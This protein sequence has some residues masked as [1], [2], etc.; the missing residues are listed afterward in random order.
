MNRLLVPYIME[1]VR[2]LE[3]GMNWLNGLVSVS[4]WIVEKTEK[5]R[6]P[7]TS[8]TTWVCPV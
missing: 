4:L 3:R 5:V 2:M 8:T 7:L 1:A 6:N